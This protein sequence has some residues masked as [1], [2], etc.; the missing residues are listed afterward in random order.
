MTQEQRNRRPAFTLIELLVVIGIIVVLAGFLLPMLSRAM[1]QSNKLRTQADFQSI[2]VAL[3]AYRQDFSDYPRI[4]TAE[5]SYGSIA[6]GAPI[7][8]TGAAILCKALIGPFGD[9]LQP[10]STVTDPSDPPTWQNIPYKLGDAVVYSGNEYVCIVDIPTAESFV[11][12][13]WAHFD[14]RDGADGPGF[15]LRI[16]PTTNQP[17]ARSTAPISKQARL[18]QTICI[19]WI[20][21]ADRSCISPRVPADRP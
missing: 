3:E 21:R 20:T 16:D 1:R 10:N 17:K 7:P 15:R 19:C 13:H 5:A 6:M 8:N 14:A 12:Q 11:N 18:R 4:P 9:G 2:G